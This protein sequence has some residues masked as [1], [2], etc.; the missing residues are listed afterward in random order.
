MVPEMSC[1]R[2]SIPRATLRTTTR[3]PSVSNEST[4]PAYRPAASRM[5]FGI[6]ACPLIVTLET[7]HCLDFPSSRDRDSSHPST[8]PVR[9]VSADPKVTKGP[10]GSSMR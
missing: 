3:S 4:S 10:A 6:V 5:L 2:S 8:T 7:F 9:L 1:R